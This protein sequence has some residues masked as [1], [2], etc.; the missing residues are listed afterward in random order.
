MAEGLLP[1]N[2]NIAEFDDEIHGDENNWEAELPPDFALISA[3]GT[4][5]KSLNDTE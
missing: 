3:L 1:L 5:P 4:E 2:T